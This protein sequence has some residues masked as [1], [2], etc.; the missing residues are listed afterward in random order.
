[1]F[2]IRILHSVQDT[3]ACSQIAL[4]A[5]NSEHSQYVPVVSVLG[6]CKLSQILSNTC[7][8]SNTS[9]ISDCMRQGLRCFYYGT[10][11][12][13]CSHAEH[14]S[15]WMDPL[16]MEDQHIARSQI[17]GIV[18]PLAISNHCT[19]WAWCACCLFSVTLNHALVSS[20][21]VLTCLLTLVTLMLYSILWHSMTS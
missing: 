2:P 9:C 11:W 1:M 7:N 5:K 8:I 6:T 18:S 19:T 3:L 13:K 4:H 16:A 15:C 14:G 21:V 17:L 10:M 12:G 20:L